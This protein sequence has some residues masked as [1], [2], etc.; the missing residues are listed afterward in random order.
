MVGCVLQVLGKSWVKLFVD[1]RAAPSL[2]RLPKRSVACLET[3]LLRL[4]KQL[5]ST[6]PHLATHLASGE[7]ALVFKAASRHK[8]E[9]EVAAKNIEL[10]GLRSRNSEVENG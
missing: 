5:L 8:M 1:I 4:Y 6:S 9:L 10:K 2:R 3:A 7:A